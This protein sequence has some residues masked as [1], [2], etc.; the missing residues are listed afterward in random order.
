MHT[1]T[2]YPRIAIAAVLAAAAFT[3]FADVA[4]EVDDTSPSVASLTATR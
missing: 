3:A 4:C 2:A 1:L